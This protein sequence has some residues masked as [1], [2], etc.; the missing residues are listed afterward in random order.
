MVTVCGMSKAATKT[1]TISLTTELLES[2]REI[3]KAEG[4]SLS[5]QLRF[6]LAESVTRKNTA[7]EGAQ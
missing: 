4:R 5:G 3:A 6:F 7:A 2:L 1:T